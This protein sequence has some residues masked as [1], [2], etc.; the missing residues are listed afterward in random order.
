MELPKG[1]DATPSIPLYPVQSA[2][3]VAAAGELPGGT[4]TAPLPSTAP[5]PART[6]LPPFWNDRDRVLA[7]VFA[8]VDLKPD[9]PKEGA[10]LWLEYRRLGG[11]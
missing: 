3:T 8:L 10:A 11:N 1:T 2:G 9:G 6:V 5:G 7:L 4:S